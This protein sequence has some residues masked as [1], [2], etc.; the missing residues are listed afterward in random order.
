MLKSLWNGYGWFFG[1][2]TWEINKSV[3]DGSG[4]YEVCL[5]ASEWK[6]LFPVIHMKHCREGYMALKPDANLGVLKITIKLIF[7]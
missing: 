5:C 3:E 2:L 6:K 4:K 7:N 1:F